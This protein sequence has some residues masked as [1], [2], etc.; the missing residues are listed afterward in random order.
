MD[1]LFAR[2]LCPLGEIFYACQTINFRGCCAD[3]PCTLG[4][5]P[6][7]SPQRPEE[8]EE[9]DEDD[10]QSDSRESDSADSQVLLTTMT[11]SGVTRT[12]ANSE[13]IT[14]T[15][16]TTIV[17]DRFPS[18]RITSSETLSSSQTTSA[19]ST[20]FTSSLTS[21]RLP[22]E[23]GVDTVPSGGD[24]DNSLPQNAIIGIATGGGIALIL[25]IVAMLFIW[26]HSKV[27]REQKQSRDMDRAARDDLVEE[28]HFPTVSAQTTGTGTHAGSDPF[29][30]FGG[31]ADTAEDPYRPRSGVFEMDGTSAAPVELPAEPQRFAHPPPV[32]QQPA[33]DGPFP[34]PTQTLPSSM[35][36]NLNGLH[37][38][39]GQPA[40]VGHWNHYGRFDGNLRVVN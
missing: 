20:T 26:R 34:A 14:V 10:E 11:D 29:A 3:D 12:I 27:S 36:P 37:N 21:S 17:T 25:L 24:L 33:V 8:D 18:S 7:D 32:I 15:R 31:R 1:S 13:V 2:S 5:C 28:K 23:T 6:Q 9:D 38:G 4:H 39:N 16:H 35:S 19:Q 40:V 22:E 30:P